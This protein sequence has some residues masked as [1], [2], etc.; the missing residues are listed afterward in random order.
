MADPTT[1]Q[2]SESVT[3]ARRGLGSGEQQRPHGR[4]QITSRQGELLDRPV[5]FAVT[6]AELR[7]F[8]RRIADEAERGVAP[9]LI[10]GCGPR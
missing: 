8:Y 1:E 3:T 10:W 7:A 5:E 6:D 4:L 9:E 2:L